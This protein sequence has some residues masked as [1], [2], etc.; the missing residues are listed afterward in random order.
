MRRIEKKNNMREK[1]G[2]KDRKRPLSSPVCVKRLKTS[3]NWTQKTIWIIIGLP[4]KVSLAYQKRSGQLL[5]PISKFCCFYNL[6]II[7]GL[8]CIFHVKE[9]LILFHNID[10]W[11]TLCTY[12]QVHWT[13]FIHVQSQ[14]S[15]HDPTV[16]RTKKGESF[17]QAKDTTTVLSLV[18][19]WPS[20]GTLLESKL[21]F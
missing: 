11:I 10:H 15:L 19:Y 8:D 6:H 13:P 7:G 1:P 17:F 3:E 5:K 9:W 4:E 20:N 21:H 14:R 16:T 12:L 2:I 18:V